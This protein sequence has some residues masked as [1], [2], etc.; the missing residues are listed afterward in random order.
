[1]LTNLLNGQGQ[2]VV[3]V[4]ENMLDMIIRSLN[5]FC[6]S[7]DQS[8]ARVRDILVKTI[9]IAK[10]EYRRLKNRGV[11]QAGGVITAAHQ[12]AYL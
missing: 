10:T 11:M 6:A 3:Q 5:K 12:I 1:M 9:A 4:I 7:T 8:K 2:I